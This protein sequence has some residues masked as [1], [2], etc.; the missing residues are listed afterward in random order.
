MNE[1]DISDT[2]GAVMTFFGIGIFIGAIT[3]IF[4]DNKITE[5]ILGYSIFG[6]ATTFLISIAV[7]FLL[8][9]E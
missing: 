4:F 8:F 1:K 5:I 6:L 9:I 2:F 7:M 3:T